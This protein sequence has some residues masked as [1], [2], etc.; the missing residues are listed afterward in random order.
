MPFIQQDQEVQTPSAD[1][2]DRPLA[3]RVRVQAAHWRLQH[4]QAPRFYREVER[5][6]IDVVVD[7]NE[8]SLRLVAR[9]NRAELL[10]GP[11]GRGAVFTG[12]EV[13]ENVRSD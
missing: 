5:Q 10:D 2:A 4:R 11:V 8:K 6:G 13:T 7:V 9:D 12:A 3:E 1:R